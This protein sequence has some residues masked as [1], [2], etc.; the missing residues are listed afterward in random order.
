MEGNE[1]DPSRF[2]DAAGNLVVAADDVPQILYLLN[3]DL[4]TGSLTKTGFRAD[5]KAA[6]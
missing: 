6:R 4:F 3:E 5:K 2:L 1:M